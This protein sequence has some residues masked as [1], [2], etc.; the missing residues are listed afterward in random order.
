MRTLLS[1]ERL[2]TLT[3][4]GGVG[5]TRVALAAASESAESYPDG[6]W[7]VEFGAHKVPPTAEASVESLAE[8]VAAA[9]AIRDDAPTR[10]STPGSQ[11]RRLAEALRGRELLLLL[12]NCEHVVRAAATL[13]RLLLRDAPNLRILATSREPLDIAGE[14]LCLV[15][16]L[17]L[18]EPGAVPAEI[19]RSGAVRLFAARAAAAAPGFVL[20]ED[21][22]EVVATIC[23]RMDG[24][25]LALELASARIRTLGPAR[26]AERL[27][28]RFG[29]LTDGRRDAPRRQQTL[30]AMIDW[31]WD[32]LTAAEQTVLRRLSVHADGCS[33]DAAE[34]LCAGVGVKSGEVLDL[35]ARLVDRSLIG[36]SH[37][38]GE[39]RYRLLESIAAYCSER[40]RAN[41]FASEYEQLRRAYARY[42]VTLAEQADAELRGAQQRRWLRRLDLESANM[43]DALD[44]AA[45]LGDVPLARRLARALTW[46]WFLRGRLTEARRSIA[47]ALAVTNPHRVTETT[48]PTTASGATGPAP[49]AIPTE[50][51][52][53][54]QL[55]AWSAALDLL[56]GDPADT[57]WDNRTPLRLYEAIRDRRE[58]IGP[59]WLLGYATTMFGAMDVGVEIVDRSLDDSR[60]EGDTWAVAAALGVRAVQRYARGELAASREDGEESRALFTAIG[61][62]W[63]MLQATGVLGRL[64]EME[65]RYREAEDRYREGLNIAEDLAL[66]TDAA[67]RW[68]ELGRIALL[69]QDYAAADDLHERAR[70]LAVAHGN[71]PGQEF[72]EVGLALSARRQG[73]LDAAE[74]YL[75]PWLDWNRGFDAAN[76]IALVLAELGFVAELRG[77]AEA[78]LALHQEGLAA[79][80]KTGDPRAVALAQEGLAGAR[81]L[82]GDSVL[83]ARLLG[84]A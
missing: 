79:A 78:A 70:N 23:R 21:D 73:R 60:L 32:L 58:R 8:T 10:T 54:A 82:A 61:D 11:V 49:A 4:P 35:L 47:A 26:L 30:R 62:G 72:A 34:T 41:E 37:D 55:E 80:R 25:P 22:A 42:Y 48:S 28:D 15:P 24:L 59:G 3:G 13:T 65:G 76:G 63:G 53:A 38:A 52:A 36:V 64:L 27:D 44:T 31:S 83:A 75:R 16:P 71:R 5:K 66:W 57:A 20:T 84:T 68:A 67:A 7:L 39:P 81:Q 6:V 51:D 1:R 50:S 14:Q 77:D 18:P 43:R 33:L 40:L 69:G 56:S 2:V 9:L 19:L 74:R 29:L 45:S 12:D 46:Y 17:D